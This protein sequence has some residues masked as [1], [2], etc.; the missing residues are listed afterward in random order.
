M[1]NV[2]NLADYRARRAQPQR[3]PANVIRIEQVAERITRH[4]RAMERL[5]Q[6][7]NL[8]WRH[9]CPL[10]HVTGMVPHGEACIW[11]DATDPDEPTPPEAA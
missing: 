5:L 7:H 9:T 6:E 3:L 1:N 11:C 10:I 2:T 4:R 8:G